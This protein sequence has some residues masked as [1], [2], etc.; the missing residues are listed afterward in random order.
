[1]PGEAVD[2]KPSGMPFCFCKRCSSMETEITRPAK[3]KGY[4]RIHLEKT[5]GLTE[6]QY[7][8]CSR[9]TRAFVL[10]IREWS[11]CKTIITDTRM[12]DI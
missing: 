2:Q 6:H 7:F 10:S 9:A 11:E 1:M 8:I 3:F 12:T 4:N 5:E